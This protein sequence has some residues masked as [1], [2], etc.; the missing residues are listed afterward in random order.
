MA[1]SSSADIMSKYVLCSERKSVHVSHVLSRCTCLEM[2]R[3]ILSLSVPAFWRPYTH[4]LRYGRYDVC[5]GTLCTSALSRNCNFLPL[6]I[7]MHFVLHSFHNSQRELAPGSL[8]KT[9]KSSRSTSLPT[10]AW[11]VVRYHAKLKTQYILVSDVPGRRP[12]F[13]KNMLN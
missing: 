12:E 11:P 10:I 1:I 5:E 3:S 8:Q 4:A 2:L 9:F 7:S 13:Q 6:G